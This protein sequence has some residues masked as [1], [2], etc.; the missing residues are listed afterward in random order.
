MRAV[1]LR[2]RCRH[3]MDSAVNTARYGRLNSTN[4][5]DAEKAPDDAAQQHRRL[6]G[7][8]RRT[9]PA[10]VWWRRSLRP[11]VD[12]RYFPPEARSAVKS[13][14]PPVREPVARTERNVL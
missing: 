3:Q 7:K 10:C 8:T 9:A 5:E 13:G 4:G 2:L 1:L 6:I 14:C 11:M 12:R